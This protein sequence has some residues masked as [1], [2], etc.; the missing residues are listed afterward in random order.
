MYPALREQNRSTRL[1]MQFINKLKKEKDYLKHHLLL[2]Y[3]RC[4]NSGQGYWPAGNTLSYYISWLWIIHAENSVFPFSCSQKDSALLDLRDRKE[5]RSSHSTD[6][7][8]DCAGENTHPPVKRD[9]QALREHPIDSRHLC[10]ESITIHGYSP[11]KFSEISHIF[12]P[13]CPEPPVRSKNHKVG[14]HRQLTSAQN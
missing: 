14:T 2:S 8:H 10:R 11:C 7:L 5:T 6:L 3:K 13:F 12:S 9:S 1:V 4:F